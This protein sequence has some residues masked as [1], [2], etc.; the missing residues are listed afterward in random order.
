VL[1][2]SCNRKYDCQNESR[3]GVTSQVLGAEEALFKFRAVREE[4]G[5][6]MVVGVAGPG[7]ALADFEKTKE[8]LQLIRREDPEID[9]CLSTNGLLLPKYAFQIISLGVGYVTIT[10][11]AVDPEIGQLVYRDIQ[12][13]GGV[14]NGREGVELLIQNQLEG[15]RILS[16]NGVICKVNIVMI[17]GVNDTHVEEIVKTVRDKGAY[18]A[19]IMPL[20]PTE[21]TPFADIP[22]STPG[23]MYEIRTKCEKHL[24]QMHH[25]MQCRADAI[26]TLAEDRSVEFRNVGCRAE[27]AVKKNNK[28]MIL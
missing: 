25:C 2:R 13:E 21:G 20:I 17:K 14:L 8:A 18:I 10:I 24:R 6:L 28:E 19:N 5:N 15:L 1:F 4:L 26:G 23:E 9:F 3:P 11:N 27:P 7:D 16:R 12:Y 22:R